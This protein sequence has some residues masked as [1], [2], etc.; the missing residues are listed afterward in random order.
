VFIECDFGN[1]I[2]IIAQ[3]SAAMPEQSGKAARDS[4]GMPM[5]ASPLG[6]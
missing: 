3:Q 4:L 1:H 2:Q 5:G 6:G